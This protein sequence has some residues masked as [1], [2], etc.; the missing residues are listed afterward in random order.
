MFTDPSTGEQRTGIAKVSWSHEA[1][2]RAIAANPCIK[3]RELAQIFDKTESWISSIKHSDAFKARLDAYLKEHEDPIVM[4]E[5]EARYR[6]LADQSLELL[7]ERVAQEANTVS[8]KSREAD[9]FLFRT[10]ELAGKA[11]G[12][13]AQ[14]ASSGPQVAVVVQVPAK[15]SAEDWVRTHSATVVSS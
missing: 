15:Q 6:A 3:N 2:I 10:A 5:I 7:Q 13:G 12:Y 8:A 9:E 1:M 14:K 11:L 4:A